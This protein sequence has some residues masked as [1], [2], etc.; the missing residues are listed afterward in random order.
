MLL[1]LLPQTAISRMAA[2]R[3]PSFFL[4][5]FGFQFPSSFVLPNKL[6]DLR[7]ACSVSSVLVVRHIISSYSSTEGHGY[8]S[9][10]HLVFLFLLRIC[11]FSFHS[12][13]FLSFY[14][15]YYTVLLVHRVCRIQYDDMTLLWSIGG[16]KI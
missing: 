9:N 11:F 13:F 5:C 3:A 16:N 15:S 4:L 7:K 6:D 12:I 2:W 10:S 8:F 1:A 14:I